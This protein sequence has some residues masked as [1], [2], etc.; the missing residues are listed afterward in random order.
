MNEHVISKH[1]GS[2]DS[3]DNDR[4]I[5]SKVHCIFCILMHVLHCNWGTLKGTSGRKIS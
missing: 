1:S 5:N 4:S 3:A 2:E